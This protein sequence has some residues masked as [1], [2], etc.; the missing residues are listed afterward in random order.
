MFNWKKK[1][2]S[3]Y[4]IFTKVIAVFF[5]V[6]L[7][8]YIWKI[9]AQ[10]IHYQEYIRG[11]KNIGDKGKIEEGAQNLA[12][13]QEV[14]KSILNEVKDKLK[15]KGQNYSE[16]EELKQDKERLKKAEEKAKESKQK[17]EEKSEEYRNAKENF[18][19]TEEQRDNTG[20]LWQ[21]SQDDEEARKKE[22]ENVR[23]KVI[24]NIQDELKRA[25]LAITELNIEFVEGA[26][27]AWKKRSWYR[28]MFYDMPRFFL[29]QP[30]QTI[31]RQFGVMNL[32]YGVFWDLLLKVL[33]MRLLLNWI[34]YPPNLDFNF[35]KSQEKSEPTD[36]ASLEEERE[37][38][39]QQLA[40][41]KQMIFN[42]GM[43]VL[44]INL[45]SLHPFTF[46]RSNSFFSSRQTN[47]PWMILYL[48][49]SLVSQFSI[50]KL[51][52]KKNISLVEYLRKSW[53]MIIPVFLLSC[54][55]YLQPN[56][57]ADYLCALLSE[58]VNILINLVKMAYRRG[59]LPKKEKK[60]QWEQKKVWNY[61][62][63]RS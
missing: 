15:K 39:M 24:K 42:M 29:I 5:I 62:N 60:L 47:L 49:I 37:R 61:K 38:A 57:F 31:S 14:E 16:K 35:A 23:E 63:Y 46:D 56:R 40:G 32:A 36:L 1:F 28:S 30:C 2:Y 18:S 21:I 33:I 3:F 51:Y 54:W 48:V 53:M 4:R 58:I 12:E 27:K 25:D 41:M 50:Y 9:S 6:I 52:S 8:S 43:F 34:S 45:F 26:D 7:V 10:I 11:E 44:L 55:F 59:R 22:L 19:S 13:I 20:K 17:Y